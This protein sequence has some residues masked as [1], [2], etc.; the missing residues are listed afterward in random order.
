MLRALERLL[1]FKPLTE[2]TILS[3]DAVPKGDE[4]NVTIRA[5]ARWTGQVPKKIQDAYRNA[6][7]SNPSTWTPSK[8]QDWMPTPQEADV[9]LAIRRHLEQRLQRHLGGTHRV[10]VTGIGIEDTLP[11]WGQDAGLRVPENAVVNFRIHA[12]PTRKTWLRQA[13]K[14][15]RYTENINV[16]PT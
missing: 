13:E 14:L 4:F 9:V 11:A 10:Q 12:R 7:L 16:E 2:T 5:T 1:L 15:K 3:V 8:E 6:V